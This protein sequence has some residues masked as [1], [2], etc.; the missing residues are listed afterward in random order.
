MY[1]GDEDEKVKKKRLEGSYYR[2]YKVAPSIFGE[3]RDAILRAFKKLRSQNIRTRANFWC[4]GSCACAAITNL[5]EERKK[6]GQ[7]PYDGAVYWHRQS[8]EDLVKSGNL[9]IY[10][11]VEAKL[12]GKG[13][14]TDPDDTERRAKSIGDKLV[15]ALRAEDLD[16]EWDGST[17]TAILVD[18]FTAK[19]WQEQ[20]DKHEF[21]E[22]VKEAYGIGFEK[23]P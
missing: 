20:A 17:G 1:S 15:A 9:Y 18:G 19:Y 13:S 22:N 8:N 3:C 4:C 23:Q 7:K 2:R 12:D 11:C 14:D 5:D 16:V 6:K 10:F 21:K